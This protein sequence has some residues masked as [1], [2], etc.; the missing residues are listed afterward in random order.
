MDLRSLYSLAGQTF[1]RHS[2]K[3]CHLY[4]P[5]RPYIDKMKKM[6]ALF[7]NVWPCID[8]H[9]SLNI[10]ARGHRALYM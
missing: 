10:L 8:R 2:I 9:S 6:V 7:N 4:G 3:E 5:K 1:A